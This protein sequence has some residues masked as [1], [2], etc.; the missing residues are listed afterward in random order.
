MRGRP[1]IRAYWQSLME[2]NVRQ[3]ELEV[4]DLEDYGDMALE[5]TRYTMRDEHGRVVDAGKYVLLWARANGGWELHCDILNS[6][7]SAPGS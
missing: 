7:L 6:N 4:L 2:T 1:Q 3:A 5:R